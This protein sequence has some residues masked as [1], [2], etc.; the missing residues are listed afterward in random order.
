[1]KNK[2]L[3]ALSAED[4][5]AKEKN[6]KKELFELNYQRK[7]GQV[8]KPSRFKSLRRTIARINTILREREIKNERSPKKTK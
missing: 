8:E 1:M 5:Q 2:E 4:L 3:T 6:F 7:V